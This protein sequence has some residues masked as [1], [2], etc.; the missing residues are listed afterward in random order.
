MHSD[1]TP[2]AGDIAQV[3]HRQYLRQCATALKVKMRRIASDSNADRKD[4][5]TDTKHGQR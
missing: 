2:R 4:L 3:R 1:T 5:F